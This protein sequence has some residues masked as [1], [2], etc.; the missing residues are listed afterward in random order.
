LK[1]VVKVKTAREMSTLCMHRYVS[2]LREI[3]FLDEQFAYAL[4]E[5]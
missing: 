2:L 5:S 4:L 3:R 1:L